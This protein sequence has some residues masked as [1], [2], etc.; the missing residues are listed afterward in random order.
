MSW[1]NGN[2]FTKNDE[3]TIHQFLSSQ[4]L[5]EDQ[6]RGVSIWHKSQVSGHLNLW[7]GIAMIFGAVLGLLIGSWF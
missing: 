5:T 2:Y 6:I 1:M 4:G 7:V 3:K